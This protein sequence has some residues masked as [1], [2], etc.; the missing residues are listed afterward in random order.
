MSTAS[1]SLSL[2]RSGTYRNDLSSSTDP[3]VSDKLQLFN[4]PVCP[5]GQRAFLAV[6][7]KEVEY[8]WVH[9]NL[10]AEAKPAWYLEVNPRGTVPALRTTDGRVIL[11]SAVCVEYLDEAYPNQ[12]TALMPSDPV[13]RAA[14]RVFAG[15]VSVAPF[16]K[17]LKSQDPSAREELI[18]G[19]IEAL[20][21]LNASYEAQS[22]AGPYFL[23]ERFSLADILLLPFLLRFQFT[24][25]HY[26]HFDLLGAMREH[27]LDRLVKMLEA[28]KERP[29]VQK[30]TMPGQYYIDGYVSYAVE[31]WPKPE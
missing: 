13:E 30:T 23:G 14:V 7:E 27:K 11:E 21:K 19:I 25:E 20:R 2:A 6:E 15:D 12:G 24:L 3:G 10:G 26:R 9:I 18:T 16:Y 31:V 29:S 5:F 4:H 8:E 17:L 22:E 28:A 1:D